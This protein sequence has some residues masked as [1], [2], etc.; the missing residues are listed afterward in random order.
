MRE[1]PGL[2]IEGFSR[3]AHLIEPLLK[4]NDSLAEKENVG[5]LHCDDT[6][7]IGTEI[8]SLAS[9]AS[10]DSRHSVASSILSHLPILYIDNTRRTYVPIT[11]TSGNTVH[12][13][14]EVLSSCPMILRSIQTD[15][16]EILRIL[17]WSVHSLVKR[18]NIWVNLSYSYGTQD[19]PHI[20]RHST[21]HHE[22]GWLV[23]CARD[24]PEKSRC[25]EIYSCFDFERMRLHW[26]GCGLLLHE[27]CHLIHQECLGLDNPQIEQLYTAA[28]KSGRYEEVLRRDW[29][30]NDQDYDM[31][32][33]MVDPKEFFAEISVTFWSKGY[34]NLDKANPTIME[35]SSPTLLEPTVAARLMQTYNLHENAYKETDHRG[36]LGFLGLGSRVEPRVRMIDPVWQKKALIQGCRNVRHCNK[37]YPFTA[38]QLKHYD[39]VLYKAMSN[40]W[41]EIAM[42]DDPDEEPSCCFRLAKL[43]PSVR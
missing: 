36:F 6:E 7:D 40:L 19:D 18:T 29:A 5:P 8:T 14:P 22:R 9:P 17:P 10:A 25:I 4:T 43:V 42:Y 3:S 2:E 37:F 13:S 16:L 33:A 11:L 41:N 31:A 34:R 27:F 39:P 24:R 1:Y 35:E 20:L 26:N 32:Y 28:Y 38:G 15:L 30:G 12:C 21:A 23:S